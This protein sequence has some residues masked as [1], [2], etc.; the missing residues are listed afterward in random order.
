MKRMIMMLVVGAAVSGWLLLVP[1]EAK[2][3]ACPPDSVKSGTDPKY[4]P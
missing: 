1:V 4:G 2:S 3:A